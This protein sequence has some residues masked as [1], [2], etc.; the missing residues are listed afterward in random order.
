MLRKCEG[1]PLAIKALGG[2]LKSQN[3]T[4]QWRKIEQDRDI[5][6]KVDDVLPSI[7]L[8]FKYLPS[9]AAKKCF[10]YCAIFK[11][12]DIIEKDRLI[13]LWM[14][15][16]LLQSYDEKEQLRDEPL[17]EKYLRILLNYSLFQ[18][19]KFDDLGNI[20]SCKM[21]DV[22]HSLVLNISK[23]DAEIIECRSLHLQGSWSSKLSNGSIAHFDITQKDKDQV[24]ACFKLGKSWLE[25]VARL[26]WRIEAFEIFGY[27]G[28]YN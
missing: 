12:D 14:A 3:S 10:A 1:M 15:Q 26:Y 16:G 11:E 25:G 8:S 2:L 19:V 23:C 13:Q 6:N 7:K 28:E 24:F 18:E 9:V 4:S 21:H 20:Q 27:I 22:V 5:W 17:G